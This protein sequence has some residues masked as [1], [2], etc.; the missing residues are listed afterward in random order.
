MSVALDQSTKRLT[1]AEYFEI[2]RAADF[3]SEF[4]D[5]EMFAMA[6]GTALHSL[7]STNVAIEFGNR[8]KGRPCVPYNADLRVKI[9]ATGLLTYPDLSVVCGPLRFV[10]PSARDTIMNPTL[11]VEV[12]SDSTEAYDRGKKFE[13]YRQ[14]PTL[15][16]YLMVSQKEPRI[17]A[18]IR[19]ENT[20]WQLREAASLEASLAIPSLD[21]TI[22]LAEVFANV[23]FPPPRIRT[24]PTR[25]PDSK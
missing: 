10:D 18:Y 16:E 20:P 5:G 14:I 12:L 25:P 15:R 21:I 17:E 4:F 7:I 11:L 1:E 19:S 13:H 9:E 8:L 22:S 6:G 24:T 23:Q 2:E 3:K